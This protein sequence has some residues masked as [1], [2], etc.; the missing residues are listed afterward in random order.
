MISDVWSNLQG[1]NK[2]LCCNN[3]Q[4][5]IVFTAAAIIPYDAEEMNMTMPNEL[6]LNSNVCHTKSS[7]CLHWAAAYSKNILK[8]FLDN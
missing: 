5:V 6:A 3:E 7:G 2:F 4:Y 8:H 1:L